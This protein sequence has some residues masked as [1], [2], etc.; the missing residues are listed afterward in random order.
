MNRRGDLIIL[1]ADKNTEYTLRGIL[2]RPPA[3]NIRE[4]RYDLYVHPENDPGCFWRAQD[5]L[6]A[7]AQRYEH[8]LVILDREG[9]GQENRSRLELEREI[10]DRMASA[11]WGDR[12]AAVVID[13]ELE[14]WV[15]SDSPHVAAVL[16]WWE[17]QPD[18]ATWLVQEGLLVAGELKPKRPKEA[19]R[20]ALR[21]V[22]KPRSSAVYQQLAQKVG[23]SRCTDP[24]FAKLKRVLQA[25]FSAERPDG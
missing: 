15:W 18:L 23:F 17:R 19:V 20:R 21:T 14:A 3:L 24:A 1:A 9:T 2:S 22:Y 7:F 11:G 4:L 10:E 25:W 5:F 16:G 8:A 6:R 12:G 13:P